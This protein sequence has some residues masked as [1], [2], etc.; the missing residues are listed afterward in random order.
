MGYSLGY[1]WTRLGADLASEGVVEHLDGD[2]SI[3]CASAS[4]LAS[5]WIDRLAMDPLYLID[6]ESRAWVEHRLEA[7]GRPFRLTDF[8]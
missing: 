7:L 3:S 1:D 4:T 5:Y 2:L 6:T 8:E